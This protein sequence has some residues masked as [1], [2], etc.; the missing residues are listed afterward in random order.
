MNTVGI[1]AAARWENVSRGLAPQAARSVPYQAGERFLRAGMRECGDQTA[2]TQHLTDR[3]L[4]H[5]R[6]L[7]VL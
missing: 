2:P 5:H 4:S 6:A 1:K 3:L 7:T